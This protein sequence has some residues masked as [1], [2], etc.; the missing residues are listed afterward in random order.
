MEIYETKYNNGHYEIYVNGKF[1]SSCDTY[2]EV[3]EEL[4]KVVNQN[5]E[6]KK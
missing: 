6:N 5:R 3:K 2:K 4:Q 1:V